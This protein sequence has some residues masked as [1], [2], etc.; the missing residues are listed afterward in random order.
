MS[1]FFQSTWWIARAHFVRLLG[2]QRFLWCAI[3]ALLPALAALVVAGLSARVGPAAL[4]AHL[5]WAMLLQIVLPLVTLLGGSAV[6]AEEVDDRTITYVFTR[7]I[8]RASLLV[9]RFLSTTLLWVLLFAVAVLLLLLASARARGSGPEID[10]H[11]ARSLYEAALVGTC[12]Y[13]ALFAGLSAA[14]KHPMILGVA[15]AFA[16]EG[17]LAN[18]PGRNQTLA[19]QYYLRSLIAEN[20]SPVWARVEG[21]SSTSFA[22][23]ER[24]RTILL[25]VVVTAL[26]IGSW[27][28]TRRQFELTA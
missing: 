22:T 6:V 27:R 13:S 21:F 9:G 4:A 24:A 15:Y 1:A 19:L 8:P 16:V 5:G 18:L 28:I 2:S 17:F 25:L 11:F 14:T 10:A 12:A 26:V 3:L 23:P 7:P 20:A